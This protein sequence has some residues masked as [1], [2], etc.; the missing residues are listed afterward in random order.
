M[1]PH[2]LYS[3]MCQL[4]NPAVQQTASVRRSWW[5]SP[6]TGKLQQAGAGILL[7]LRCFTMA[8]LLARSI[9]LIAVYSIALQVLLVGYLHASHLGFDPVAVICKGG[10][11]SSK[12]DQPLSPQGGTC[13][14]CSL[15]CNGISAGIV[16]PGAKFSVLPPCH[17]VG[18]SPVWVELVSLPARYHPQA[19]RAPPA[20]A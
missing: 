4:R 15:V 6:T 7:A 17:L 10:D 14:H 20:S 2:A 19:S 5:S 11:G 12:H 1:P 3:A 9:A 18:S 8:R 13:D 16:P